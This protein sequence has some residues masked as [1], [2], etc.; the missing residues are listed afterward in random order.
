MRSTPRHRHPD[1][2]DPEQPTTRTHGFRLRD[3]WWVLGVALLC[4][5]ALAAWALA[6]AV[7]RL[8]DRPPGDGTSI[9]SYECDLRTPSID[10]NLLQPAMLHRDMI[11]V[12][13]EPVILSME[14]IKE[15]NTD[16]RTRYLVSS[17]LVIGVEHGGEVRAYPISVLN[18]HE[19]I[20][21]ELGGTPILVSWH[22]PSASARVLVRRDALQ[23]F[24]VSGLV[25]G[26]N[27]LYYEPNDGMAPGGEH[28]HSQLLAQTITGPDAGRTFETLP[29]QFARWEDW[30]TRH[31]ETTA[32]APDPDLKKRYKKSSPFTYYEHDQLMFPEL[33]TSSGPPDK[34]WV[35]VVE[36]DGQTR[37][38]SWPW[39]QAQA[40]DGAVDS[41]LADRRLRF[42]VTTDPDT[43]IVL[44]AGT[45]EPL[46]S[47]HGLWCSM[48]ALK[49][50]LDVMHKGS[51]L[52]Q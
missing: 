3:G 5:L 33:E 45:M 8:V 37:A 11:P 22:W 21:D 30:S 32:I 4:S 14:D 47:L 36:L 51:A 25:G 29:H 20:H 16:R 44:D 40:V 24:R 41:S 12:M 19:L 6:P 2:M 35:T 38:W 31:P 28:L 50:P 27:G 1:P 48:E 39:L 42:I 13:D 10:T 34:T 18:V 7:L 52:S 46:D 9:E 15:R 26:G 43:V 23:Q 49:G 17:D